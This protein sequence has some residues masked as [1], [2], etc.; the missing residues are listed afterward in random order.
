MAVAVTP[1]S[2]HSTTLNGA[3]T[4]VTTPA[5]TSYASGP[6]STTGGGGGG[7]GGGGVTAAGGGGGGATVGGAGGGGGG[8]AG[9]AA[10]GGAGCVACWAW[11]RGWSGPASVTAS[12]TDAAI[13]RSPIVRVLLGP[14]LT[15][16]TPW[17]AGL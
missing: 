5:A 4:T 7:G 11:A 13:H 16:E 14:I 1:P 8:A 17:P 9:G 15:P 2:V 12:A 6:R 3:L 10:S